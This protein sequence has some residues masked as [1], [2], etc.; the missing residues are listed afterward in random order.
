MIDKVHPAIP[1]MSTVDDIYGGHRIPGGSI[2][3]GNVWAMLHDERVYKD[4]FSFKPERFLGP[5]PEPDPDVLFG[6]GRR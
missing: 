3:I 4:P 2:V 6:F 5:T 1:H